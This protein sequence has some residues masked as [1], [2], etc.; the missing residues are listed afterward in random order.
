MATTNKSLTTYLPPQSVEWLE[1]YC[2]DYKHLQNK[3]GNP[4]LGTA[5]ADIIA[6]LSD[7]ELSL[8]VAID[9]QSTLLIQYGTEIGQM[10]GEIEELKKLISEYGT[11]N[12]PDPVLNLEVVKD[13]IDKGL[14]PTNAAII[15]LETYAKSQFDAVREELKKALSVGVASLGENRAVIETTDSIARPAH[16][17]DEAD[18][19]RKTWRDFFT[20]VGM[21]S[22]TSGEA[23]KK[24]NIV[25]RD[26]QAEEGMAI[27]KE[28]GLGV[29]KVTRPGRT[30]VK[31]E[32]E[33][34]PINPTN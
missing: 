28:M 34:A 5:I 2:L 6:R 11:P 30:F 8:P 22:M 32:D 9:P 24:E 19:N 16:L 25:L 26:K 18:P 14:Q 12:L 15:E 31:V 21:S 4:K 23:K 3:E 20:M 17:V 7:G 10:R 13:E 27:A 33:A 1:K 29:W